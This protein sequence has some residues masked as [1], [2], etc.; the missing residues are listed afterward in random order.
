MQ[1]TCKRCNHSWDYK[2]NADRVSCSHCRTS[3][4]VHKQP[5]E[6]EPL[7]QG[8]FRLYLNELDS[9]NFRGT[10]ART[11]NMGEDYI[12]LKADKDGILTL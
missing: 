6:P 5:P 1:L 11:R 2:G 10:V 3:I 4:T 7:K 8:E 9:H 12:T